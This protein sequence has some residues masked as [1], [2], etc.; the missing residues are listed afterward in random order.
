MQGIQGMERCTMN[1]KQLEEQAVKFAAIPKT[2]E[3]PFPPFAV[4]IH[5][6]SVFQAVEW[7]PGEACPARG[8]D[9]GPLDRVEAGDKQQAQAVSDYFRGG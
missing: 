9:G 3:K 8:C 1:I 7:S 5:C 4:C 2:T 6:G